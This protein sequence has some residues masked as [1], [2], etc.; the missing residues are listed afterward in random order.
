MKPARHHV[1]KALREL[2]MM[3]GPPR[4]PQNET[5]PTVGAEWAGESR[6]GQRDMHPKA[7]QKNSTAGRKQQY[8]APIAKQAAVSMYCGGVM[9]LEGVQA[10]FNRH[11]AW[12]S[13]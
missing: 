9:S 13:E 2:E 10:M 5:G 3:W 6:L 11:P 4:S 1:A 7:Q 8:P 12:R